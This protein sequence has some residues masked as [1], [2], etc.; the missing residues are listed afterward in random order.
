MRVARLHAARD[1]RLSVEPDAVAGDGES[2]IRVGAVGICGSDLHWW[3]EG[4]VGET[5]LADPVVPGH[6]MAGHVVGG[7]WDG[8]L[9]AID[10]AIPCGRCPRCLEGD[11]NL[12]PEVRFAGHGGTDG[13]LRELMA[14]PT[15]RLHPLPSSMD[16]VDGAVLEPLGVALHA[17]DLAHVRLGM[18][19]AVV[20]L[21]PIGL[22]AVQLL[23]AAGAV[24]VVGV[25]PLPHRREAALAAGADDAVPPQ[26]AEALGAS[27]G[28]GADVVL[29]I[30]GNDDA[31]ATAV[32]LARPGARVLLAGIP[33]TP[34]SA[35]PAAVA[36]RKGLSLLLVRRMK[37]V[38]PRTI[39]LVQS[40]LVDL[41]DVVTHRFGL[42]EAATGFD[43]AAERAGLKTVIL[44]Q[45]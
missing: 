44:P 26:D 27:L 32:A 43:R 37:D 30:A 34:D 45:S 39:A 35:Y 19:A 41:G 36:R 13:P 15:S 29:E 1:L 20:G 40:G 8:Q 9:V 28:D 24:R 2:L 18:T 10:P 14:W 7:P 16:P 25:E 4:S 38:Y 5:A 3:T 11:P 33:S 17:V 6:E 12:C 22:L 21:G 23:R 31:I 42:S